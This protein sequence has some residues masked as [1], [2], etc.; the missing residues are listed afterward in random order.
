MQRLISIHAPREGR[1]RR[2]SDAGSV[3]ADFNPRAPRGARRGLC[4][5]VGTAESNFNP[6]APRGA[7]LSYS[8]TMSVALIFQSTRPARGAT[9]SRVHAEVLQK[10]SIHAP[11]EGRDITLGATQTLSVSD[12]NPRAP[13]GARRLP[14]EFRNADYNFNPRAPRG[15][16]PIP[17]IT[18]SKS[19][20]ISIHAPREGRDAGN[21]ETKNGR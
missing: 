14:V 15:A 4:E 17:A 18:S 12:F 5:R 6:R 13:R 3:V 8:C 16:R 2:I 7:R 9:A 10:I 1:D 21:Q 19:F 20:P 11:R